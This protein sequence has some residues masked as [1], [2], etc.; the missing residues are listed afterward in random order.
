MG[1]YA[2]ALKQF[3]DGEV[4]G[5]TIYS[6][7]CEAASDPVERRKWAT[8]LQLET[9]TKAWMRPHLVAHGVGVEE[10]GDAVRRRAL[11]TVRPFLGRPW[12]EQVRWI[13]DVFEQRVVPAVQALVDEAEARS[14][15]KATAVCRYYLEHERIQGVFAQRELAGDGETSLELV[16]PFLKYPI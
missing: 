7:L 2:E 10:H 6:A 12:G 5:E 4:F 9:E 15:E 14:D 13:A 3:Y 16:T 8:L 1:S 11:E